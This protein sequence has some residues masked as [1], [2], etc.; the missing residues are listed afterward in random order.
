MNQ[1]PDYARFRNI[2]A[3]AGFD[4]AKLVVEHTGTICPVETP[5]HVDLR[6][7]LGRELELKERIGQGGMGQ[8]RLAVQVPLQREVAVKCAVAKATS[9]HEAA[10]ALLREARVMGALEHPNIVPVH[11]L[12]LTSD[13]GV[14]IVMKRIEGT[15]WSDLLARRSSCADGLERHIA[16]LLEVCRAVHFAHTRGVIHRDLKPHNVMVGSFD[17]VYVLDWGIAVRTPKQTAAAGEHGSMPPMPPAVRSTVAGT[18]AYMAPE[19]ALPGGFVDAR[20]DVYLL[21]GVLHTIVTGVPPHHGERVSELLHCAFV[22]EQ[23]TYDDT[24]PSE[25]AGICRTALAREPAERFQSVDEF[26]VALVEFLAHASARALAAEARLRLATFAALTASGDDLVVHRAFGEMRFGFEQ[27][28]RTWPAS[29]EARDGQ[30]AALAAM[31]SY[32]ISRGHLDAARVLVD[33]I[34]A[35]AQTL[36]DDLAALRASSDREAA[37]KAQLDVVARDIDAGVGQRQR[38]LIFLAVALAWGVFGVLTGVLSRAGVHVVTYLDLVLAHAGVIALLGVAGVVYRDKVS[39]GRASRH[40]Y[41]S[42]M[43]M[44]SGVLLQWIV[45]W[46]TATPLHV[47]LA[48]AHVLQAATVALTAVLLDKRALIAAGIIL[49]GFPLVLAL[50]TYAFEVNAIVM[51]VALMQVAWVWRR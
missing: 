7:E 41:A 48:L 23:K 14:L 19:M 15:V 5:T 28:L 45:L 12:N 35:P 37:R 13:G 29:P 18:P 32:E 8:V 39:A 49:A 31:A 9:R 50:S 1:P 27:A 47:G 38:G 46:I 30:R 3:E 40:I 44:V 22:S 36:L 17:E 25:L 16:V 24:V 21:G 26:R 43:L 6:D 33:E 20:T 51:M 2:L 10:A 11:A 42:G 34:E 4:E